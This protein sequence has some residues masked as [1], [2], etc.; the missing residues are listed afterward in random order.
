[1]IKT[2]CIFNFQKKFRIFGTNINVNNPQEKI[3]IQVLM[4]TFNSEDNEKTEIEIP[5]IFQLN[6]LL[7]WEKFKQDFPGLTKRQTKQII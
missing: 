3:S 7:L 5:E 2:E 6:K 1:M 4:K